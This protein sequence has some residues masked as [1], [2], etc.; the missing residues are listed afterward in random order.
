MQRISI[1][2]AIP[3]HEMEDWDCAIAMYNDL[4]F[5]QEGNYLVL[6]FV[7]SVLVVTN[8]NY[9][10]IALVTTNFTTTPF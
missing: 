3:L 8:N 10:M 1:R 9:Q 2:L 7:F 6:L 5:L 4:T